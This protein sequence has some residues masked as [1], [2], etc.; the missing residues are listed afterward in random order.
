MTRSIPRVRDGSLQEQRAEDTSTDTISIGTAEWY[1]WLEQH[2]AFTF[3][4][5]STTFTARKE[6]RPE[7]WYWY[8]YRRMR[9]K[10]HNFYLG[11][12]E[13][14]TLERLNAAAEVFEPAGEA[15]VDRTTQPQRM[16]RDK[17]VQ[18]QPTSIITFPTTSTI[19]ERL[20]EPEPSSTHRIPVPLTP[21]M[22]REQ[23]AASVVALLLLTEVCL[24]TR[25]GPGAWAKHAWVSRSRLAC[26]LTSRMGS[27]L[28]LWHPSGNPI[29]CCLSLHRPLSSRKRPAGCHWN[30]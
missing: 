1:S 18:V 27:R 20:R 12:S 4:T 30:T 11:K 23:D 25:T 16:S 3:E 9:G 8:A 17:A 26:F 10:L 6:Q 13:E 15:L 28:F 5:P 7:G 2:H 29:W 22:G 19:A 14:L 21:L 24:L